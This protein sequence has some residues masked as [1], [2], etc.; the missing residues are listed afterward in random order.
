LT[1][2][3]YKNGKSRQQYMMEKNKKKVE[4]DGI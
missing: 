1:G 2:C 3:K 4:R